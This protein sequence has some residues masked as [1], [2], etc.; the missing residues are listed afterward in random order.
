MLTA[1][2]AGFAPPAVALKLRLNGATLSAGVAAACVTESATL[3][4]CGEFVAF[5]V[6][7]TAPL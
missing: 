1:C 6:T 3:T 7:R 5:P 2:A 4:V